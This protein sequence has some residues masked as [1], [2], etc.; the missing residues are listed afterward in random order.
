MSSISHSGRNPGEGNGN[1]F[2]YSFF[3]FSLQYSTWRIPRTEELGGL[4]CVGSQRFR[5]NLVTK[6]AIFKMSPISYRVHAFTH[7]QTQLKCS[8]LK[9]WL[10]YSVRKLRG[11]NMELGF[12]SYFLKSRFGR[13]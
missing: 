7:R 13:T 1:P 6:T 8:V 10:T 3:S 4:Q 11:I 5:Y 2:R 9:M 12:I